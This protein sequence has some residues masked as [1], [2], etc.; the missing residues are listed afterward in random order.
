MNTR[1]ALKNRITPASAPLAIFWA[2]ARIWVG[3]T[4]FSAGLAK[5]GDPAWTGKEAGTA[6]HGFLGYSVSPAMT[7][8]PHPQVLAPYS[9]M[10]T[11]MFMPH[12]AFLSYLVSGSETLV[13]A[14]LILGL[15]TRFAALGGALLNINYLLAGSAGINTPMLVIELSIVLVGATAGT[16]G[17]DAFLMPVVRTQL[18]RIRERS[19]FLRSAK[20]LHPVAQ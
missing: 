10:A 3:W 1:T 18:D 13:G 15:C 4:F 12:D 2:V 7:G 11:H 8:G 14:A 6:L 19:G 17:V 16:I 20:V 5:I 9:W